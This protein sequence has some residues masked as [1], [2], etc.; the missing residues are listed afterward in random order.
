MVMGQESKK[1]RA[2]QRKGR[3]ANL[4]KKDI[5]HKT[6]TRKGK[7]HHV[8][9]RDVSHKARTGQKRAHVTVPTI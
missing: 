8:E 3:N 5:S 4:E 7:G 6:R 9:E 1:L 2:I